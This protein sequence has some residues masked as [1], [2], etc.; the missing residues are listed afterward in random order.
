MKNLSTFFI[1]IFCGFLI[2]SCQNTNP[3]QADAANSSSNQTPTTPTVANNSTPNITS[4]SDP[5]T[6]TPLPQVEGYDYFN[7]VLVEKFPPENQDPNRYNADN[8]IYKPGRVFIYGYYYESTNGQRLL[9]Q[10]IVSDSIPAS[11]AWQFVYANQVNTATITDFIYTVEDGMGV[12]AKVRADYNRTTVKIVYKMPT[13]LAKVKE[14]TGFIE[15]PQGVWIY[16]PRQKLFGILAM[17]P[18]PFIKAPY[19]VGHQWDWSFDTGGA[20][21]DP[22]WIEWGNTLVNNC[23]YKIIGKKTVDSPLGQLECFEINSFGENRLGRTQLTSYFNEEYGFV[24]MNYLNID[25][26]KVILILKEIKES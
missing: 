15:N 17:N 3:G 5:V 14:F 26:S 21:S 16:P 1:A 4:P 18:Q 7:G 25:G 20:Y 23:R 11:R 22:R 24:Q 19:E 13:G 8:K 9:A 6:I 10:N 12:L 2:F